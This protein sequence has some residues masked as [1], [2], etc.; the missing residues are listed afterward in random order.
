MGASQRSTVAS[1]HLFTFRCTDMKEVDSSQLESIIFSC[2]LG[3]QVKADSLKETSRGGHI[4]LLRYI[5]PM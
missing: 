1:S 5:H 4:I 2:I 3:F